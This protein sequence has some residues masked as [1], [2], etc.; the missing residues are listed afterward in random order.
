MPR[1]KRATAV[2][3]TSQ[4]RHLLDHAP[5]PWYGEMARRRTEGMFDT[6]TGEFLRQTTQQGYRGDSCWSRG[7]AWALYGF[8]ARAKPRDQQE[9]P[10]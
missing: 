5:P 1:A 9:S 7:L 10:R 8:S 3:A 4:L 6:A 2:C